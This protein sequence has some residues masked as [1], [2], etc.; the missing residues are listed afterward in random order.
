MSQSET[1]SFELRFRQ[2]HLDFHTSEHI[3]HIGIDFDP[4]EFAETLAKAHVNSVTCF[5]R[6]HHGWIYYETKK[7]PERR[8]PKLERN[9]LKEQIE[10]CHA[11]GIR[12]PIYTTIQWDHYTAYHHPE[13]LILD[14][15]GHPRGTPIYEPGFYRF[16]CVNSPYRAFLK[17]HV[18]EIL[19]TFPVDGFF[20][21]IVKPQDCSCR[22]CRERMEQAGLDPTDAHDRRCFG[23]MTINEFK[24][25]MSAFVRQYAPDASIF[26][27]AGHIGPRHRA[28]KSSY[29]HFEVESLPGGEWG[30][31][32][33]PITMRYARTLGLDCLSHTGKFHTWWG[34]FH[35]FRNRAALEFEC[36]RMLALGAKCMIGDQL[37]PRGKID[38]HVYE[39]IGSVYAQVKKK[40]PWCAKAQH[41]A[42]IAVLTPEAFQPP[43]DT[44]ERTPPPMRGAIRMLEEGAHQFDV[45][46]A[47][48]EFGRYKL[49]IL[50]DTIPVSAELATKLDEY[51]R[52]GGALIASFR[53][54]LNP[55]GSK[56][57]VESLG[58]EWQGEA[59]YHP[60]FLRPRGPI[61]AGLAPTEHV[62]YLRGAHVRLKP[63][64]H[65]LV[66]TVIP[67]FNRTYK[68]FCSHQHTPSSGEPAYPGIVQNGRAIYFAHPIFTQYDHRAPLWCKRLLLNAIDL[69]LPE[70][71]IRHDGPSTLQVHLAQQPHHNRWIVHLLHYIPERRSQTLDIIE[72]VIPLH[73]IQVSLNVPADVKAVRC[74]PEGEELPF[75]RAGSRVI[76]TLPRLHGHQMVE[77]TF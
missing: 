3:P 35:S 70:P 8:H 5:A 44:T 31:L 25:E 46:D 21:D 51:V 61:G 76:W 39:L 64:A 13:W 27:N 38:K 24:Q 57:T 67:Y 10:A 36:F 66:E 68:H 16:L 50:P 49:L 29:S 22:Y 58:V 62:M 65:V 77:V 72:D 52:Q 56:F 15:Q 14:E 6:C 53:S 11:K 48:A 4:E 18:H 45:V 75:E 28:A 42:E 41:I 17:E 55:E 12:V 2:I 20:F 60:D 69:L 26:Y 59:P 40:E 43:G 37:H 1:N 34:D 33:F 71:L 63:G 47:Q 32:H 19:E 73:D 9:L 23:L 7:H 30:Y 74:V 54:G